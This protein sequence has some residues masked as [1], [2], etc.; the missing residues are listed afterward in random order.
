MDVVAALVAD[1]QPPVLVQPGD[2]SLDHPSLLAEA[3]AV[4]AL[5]PGDLGLD[6][7]AAELA[8]TLA[9][10]V[11]AIAIQ[12]A[13]PAARTARRPRT[14]GMASS[15]G[16]ISMMSLRLPPVSEQASGVPRPQAIRWCL[17][18]LLERSTGLGPVLVP[19]RQPAR[20]SCRSLPAT[21]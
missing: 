12:L 20:A 19:P 8:P 15:N 18:P 1:A 2:R 7:T 5:R 6:A 16:I 13:R 4:G 14:G 11:S 17:E 9:R 3:G 21:S 10:V